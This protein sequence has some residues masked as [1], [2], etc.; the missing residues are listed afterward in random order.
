MNDYLYNISSGNPKVLLPSIWSSLVEGFIRLVPAIL[1]ID[2]FNTIYI[3]FADPEASLN[4]HRL[5]ITSIILLIW[6]LPQFI[7]SVIAYNRSYL[8]AYQVSAEGRI[9]LAE[10]IRKLSLGFFGSRD[11]AEL[12]NM[13][14]S[15]YAL[16]E[17]GVSHHVPQMISSIVFPI[18]AFSG[19]VFVNWQLA[20]AM[21]IALPLA[22]LVVW[23]TD[24]FQEKLSKNHIEAKNEAASRLQ[25]Y[26]RGIREIKAHNMGGERFE[27][28]RRSFEELMHHSIRI[29]G[30]MGP[31]LMVAIMLVRSGL[32]IMIFAGTYLVINGQVT[33]P[34]FLMFLLVGVRV[35]E[36]MTVLLTSYGELRYGAYSA[37]RVMTIIK[38]KPLSGEQLIPAHQPIIFDNVTF[39]YQENEPVLKQIGF[40]IPSNKITALVGPSGSGKST[41]TKLIARFWDVQSGQIRIGDQSLA[42]A[43]PEELLRHISMVFQDVYLFKDTILNNIR[44]GKQDA[45]R[46]EIEEAAKKAQCHDF[47]MSLPQGYDTMVGEGGSTLSGGEKQ[48]ISIARALLKDADI[49]LLDEA[50]ASLDPENEQAVQAAIN[51]L[52]VNKTVVIIA[53]RLKT[54]KEADQIIVLDQ[55][56]IVEWGNHE[57][58]LDEGGVYARLWN[59]QQEAEGWH[60]Q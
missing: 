34:I 44:V 43:N 22:V 25:E 46:E 9:K 15:D 51:A 32:S 38:E 33:L 2:V 37:K 19:L 1:I 5:W 20:I 59:L 53:H 17:Q 39:G 49:I 29:E 13:M 57:Q 48:R 30:L 58:L 3:S 40:T 47:I 26:L 60:L 24:H 41:I 50:T 16:V 23:T 54:I 10:H 31:I 8:A 55:G 35:F 42:E 27:R 56:K 6:L 14:L 18:L 52:V 45:T 36:P 21:F 7:S 28:L 12:T 4:I 11:P